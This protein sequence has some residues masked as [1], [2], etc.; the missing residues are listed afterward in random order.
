MIIILDKIAQIGILVGII[1]IFQ[2][3]WVGGLRMGFF[4]TLLATVLHIVTSHVII[5]DDR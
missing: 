1:A 4:V 5:S 2:P 3:Y